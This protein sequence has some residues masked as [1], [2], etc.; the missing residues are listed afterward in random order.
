[1]S[2]TNQEYPVISIVLT[3]ALEQVRQS[4]KKQLESDASLK[5]NRARFI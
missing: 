2:N 4:G 5:Q 3:Q 1:M